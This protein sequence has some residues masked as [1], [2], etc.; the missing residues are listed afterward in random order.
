MYGKTNIESK[1]KLFLS[2]IFSYSTQQQWTISLSDCDLQR[3]VDFIW[4]PVT[5]SSVAGLRRSSRALPKATHL[6]KKGHGRCL[7]VCCSCDPVQ[8][9]NPDKTITSDKYAQQINEMHQKLQCL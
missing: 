5:T 7:V 2:V 6:M 8:L 3:K 1:K 4:Q 9:L